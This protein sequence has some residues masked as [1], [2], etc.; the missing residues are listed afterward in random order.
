M[1]PKKCVTRLHFKLETL[2]FLRLAALLIITFRILDGQPVFLL[3]W[4]RSSPGELEGSSDLHTGP[5]GLGHLAVLLQQQRHLRD[6][7]KQLSVFFRG[8]GFLQLLGVLHQGVMAV[9]QQFP[10]PTQGALQ[11]GVVPL[12]ANNRNL[13][14]G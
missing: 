9:Q 6:R 2:A 4:Q 5:P 1:A 7:W 8:H 12:V 10:G 14:M 13:G 3:L 11:V